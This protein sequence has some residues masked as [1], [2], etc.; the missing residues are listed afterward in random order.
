MFC[1]KESYCSID[2]KRTKEHHH[3]TSLL[4][5]GSLGRVAATVVGLGFLDTA[6]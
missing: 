4:G 6:L 2:I 3:L 1:V 5:L